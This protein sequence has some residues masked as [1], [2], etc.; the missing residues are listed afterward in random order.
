MIRAN[1]KKKKRLVLALTV[2]STLALLTG[3]GTGSSTGPY[4]PGGVPQPLPGLPA[5]CAPITSPVGFTASNI[6]FSWSSVIG[7]ILPNNGQSVGQVI[8]GGAAA[9]GPYQRSGVDGSI[10]MNITP[11]NTAQPT[12]G[13]S[14]ST[15]YY[16]GTA[17]QTANA[18]GIVTISPQVQQQI[19]MAYGGT[20]GSY[21]PTY[22][23]SYPTSY[24]STYPSTYP[25]TMPMT[26][27]P[28]MGGQQVCVSGIAF[29]LGHYGTTLYGG[30]V[31]LYLN[32]TQRGYALYF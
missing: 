1:Q 7:G 27:M 11:M 2:A 3:C 32:G 17:T 13:T 5:G 8:V 24:P 12:Y 26:Q 25:G 20:S 14:Y 4:P 19:M 9:G 29:N 22:G 6:Y 30:N 31:F 21:Y 10:S 16:G 15:G 18:T 28:T 23:T